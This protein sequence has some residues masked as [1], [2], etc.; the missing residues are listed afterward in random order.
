MDLG[1]KDR[2]A[3][4]AGASRGL[5]FAVA[6]ALGREGTKIAI[7]SRNKE[8]LSEAEN[9]LRNHGIDVFSIPSD[10][11]IPEQARR[12]VNESIGHFGSADILVNNAGGPP[13][14]AFE[15]ISE[16]MWEYGFRL[17]LLSTIVMTKTVIPHMK[18]RKWGRI[19]NMT[20]IAV[21]QPIDGLILSN[22]IRLGVIG[23][24][25]TLSKELAP[26]NITI[27]NVCP[28]YF[29]TQRVSSLTN[30]IAIKTGVD[31]KDITRRW[32]KEIP[33]GRLGKPK[34]FGSLVCYLCS[35]RASYIT[36]TSIQID[37]GL[38]SGTM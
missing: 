8:H 30:T 11:S 26:Y 20:S 38:Y 15:E 19:I 16:D 6:E 29:L 37:G 12:F 36:G 23:L 35:D 10:V 31:N 9:T 3:L 22:T 1:I 4:V 27:N 33:A 28:G 14:M 34:E 21:K 17:N 25:K 13:S 32:E 7:C 18:A 2:V 5:G 24:A